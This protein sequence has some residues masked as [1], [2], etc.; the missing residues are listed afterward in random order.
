MVQSTLT[1]IRANKLFPSVVGESRDVLSIPL[2]AYQ[3]ERGEEQPPQLVHYHMYKRYVAQKAAKPARRAF[4]RC[5][6]KVESIIKPVADQPA[7]LRSTVSKPS[8]AKP[9]L[10]PV[11]TKPPLPTATETRLKPQAFKTR[12]RASRAVPDGFAAHLGVGK[13]NDRLRFVSGTDEPMEAGATLSNMTFGDETIMAEVGDQTLMNLMGPDPVPVGLGL[14]GAL[15]GAKVGLGGVAPALPTQ[16]AVD[17]APDFDVDFDTDLKFDMDD[18]GLGL[19][20]GFEIREDTVCADPTP[21]PPAGL[22]PS[23][24]GLGQSRGLPP[25][26]TPGILASGDENA[27]L[28]MVTPAPATAGLRRPLSALPSTK[29]RMKDR[30]RLG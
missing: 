24:L 9:A 5:V 3:N 14:G 13:K 18:M 12:S 26:R 4:G 11:A 1:I 6:G 22:R 2:S 30:L 20:G 10:V 23:G 21:A 8:P 16:P 19:D 7:L 17:P 15:G 28:A 27:G 25:A 29:M